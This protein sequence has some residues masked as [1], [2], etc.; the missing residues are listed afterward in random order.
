M[1]YVFSVFNTKLHDAVPVETVSAL[2]H[3]VIEHKFSQ[4]LDSTRFVLEADS[5]SSVQ[6]QKQ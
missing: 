6:P 4:S 1:L 3:R 5:C 2:Q